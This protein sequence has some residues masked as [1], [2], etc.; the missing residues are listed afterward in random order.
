LHQHRP[1]LLFATALLVLLGGSVVLYHS[2]EA[3]RLVEK[4]RQ[5]WFM[6]SAGLSVVDDLGG[7][8]FT[9]YSAFSLDLYARK[10]AGDV[11]DRRAVATAVERYRL[12]ARF[13]DLLQDL[14]C[15]ISQADGSLEY[16]TWNER[17]WSEAGRPDWSP[18]LTPLFQERNEGPNRRTSFSLSRPVLTMVLRSRPRPGEVV[19]IALRFSPRVILEEV[20]PTFVRQR[21]SEASEKPVYRATVR[22]RLLNVSDRTPVD[23]EIPLL[24]WTPFESWFD[25]HRT[26]MTTLRD[27]PPSYEGRPRMGELYEGGSGWTLGVV[28]LPSGLG[29][30]MQRLQWKNLG[31]AT[32]FFLVLALGFWGLYHAV[33]QARRV[34]EQERTFLALISHELKTPLAVVRSLGDNLAQG[35][36]TDPERSREYGEVIRDESDRLGQMIGNVLGLTAVQSGISSQDRVPV[37]LGAL[38]RDR[39]GR[40]CVPPNCE[41]ELAIQPGLAPVL[42]HQAALAASVDN[43]VSNAFR[44][45]VAGPGPHRIRLAVR[46]RRR[47]GRSGVEFSVNDNGPGFTRAEGRALRRPFHRGSRARD[48]QTPG[49]GVGLSLVWTTARALGGELTWSGSPGKGAS[50]QL[51]LR[52]AVP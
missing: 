18:E 35:I 46:S 13:P 52:E 1:A 6:R 15:L 17:G 8:L 29:E 27:L 28:R 34:A 42:G 50:F 38:V 40:Q 49:G 12:Q 41:V 36:V 21:F 30:E 32:G 37:E 48:T 39:V 26:R 3:D 4:A 44:H 24:P 2:L 11:V 45:G 19:A 33:R 10:E 47:W 43:L 20:V 25:Y 7:E 14:T 31:F 16:A 22:N 9:M 51:W 23:W 5:E